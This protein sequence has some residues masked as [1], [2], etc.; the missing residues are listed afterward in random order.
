MI[1]TGGWRDCF[2]LSAILIV[3]IA[4]SQCHAQANVANPQSLQ[5]QDLLS[6]MHPPAAC[7]TKSIFSQEKI[8]AES[9]NSHAMYWLGCL[10]EH[11]Q[12]TPQDSSA[13]V[14][15]Y[16]KAAQLGSVQAINR[17]GEMYENGDGVTRDFGNAKFWFTKAAHHRNSHAMNQLGMLYSYDRGFPSDYPTALGW[18]QRSAK[19]GDAEAMN[20]VGMMYLEARG[21][22]R[23]YVKARIWF[24]RAVSK[25][26]SSGMLDLGDMYD[27]ALGV[28]KDR[29]RA[30]G[31]YK[32][33]ATLD[34][35][36]ALLMLGNLYENGVQEKDVEIPKDLEKAK[37]YY[38]SAAEQNVASAMYALGQLYEA[39]G[40][41]PRDPEKARYWYERAAAKAET[42]PINDWAGEW[43][44]ERLAASYE[45]GSFTEQNYQIAMQWY[46]K[47]AGLKSPNAMERIS[48]L[49]LRGLGVPKDVALG[50]EWHAKAQALRP[51]EKPRTPDCKPLALDT[52]VRIFA[53][54][55]FQVIASEIRNNTSTTCALGDR[56]L[57]PNEMVHRSRRWRTGPSEGATACHWEMDN[58]NLENQLLVSPTLLPPVCSQIQYS[59]YTSGPF[60][61]DWPPAKS[62]P[63]SPEPRL[64]LSASKQHYMRGEVVPL[65]VSIAD[66]EHTA[67][68]SKQGCPIFLRSVTHPSGL[69]RFDEMSPTTPR[70][71]QD[72]VMLKNCTGADVIETAEARFDFD[73]TDQLDESSPGI[74]QFFTLAGTSPYGEIRLV[75]S[76]SIPIDFQDPADLQR[77]W[78]PAKEGV[79]ASLMIDKLTYEIGEDIPLHIAA[80]VV[81]PEHSVYGEP[82]TVGGSF[83]S[84]FSGSFHLTILGED[85]VPVGKENPSNLR[86]LELG[87]SSGPIACPS[88]LEIARVYPLE[89]SA[90]RLGLLPT[91]PGTYRIT[92]TWSPYLQSDPPCSVFVHSVDRV[93]SIQTLTTVSSAPLTISITGKPEALRGVPDVPVYEGWKDRFRVVDTS[94]GEATA[95]EDLRSRLQWLRLTL[96]KNQTVDSLRKQMA[97]QGRLSGWRF[98]TRNE[99]QN[100]F[101]NFTGSADGHSTDPGI[102]RALQHLLGGPLE[103]PINPDTGWSRRATNAVLADVRPARK[104]ET[105]R[106]PA[107]GPPSCADCGVG[108]IYSSGYIAEDTINGQITATVEIRTH[109]WN[110]S[111]QLSM[112][113]SGSGILLV[114][115]AP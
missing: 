9:G 46:L 67:P 68:R 10:Y 62:P 85:G 51:P 49:Y 70:M 61:P 102:E 58:S 65:H 29:A 22:P 54:P 56:L 82:D 104:D 1:V 87:G 42:A 109:S 25:G 34:N 31:L 7:L 96:T 112:P 19:H 80:Q 86:I 40:K 59:G 15:W 60:I 77:A 90:K 99:L 69:P 41:L 18:F 79:Q 88:P 26:N 43:A 108:F 33:A 100:F 48:Y 17:L 73:G 27:H 47:A 113:G 66:S 107:G 106:N 24:E 83:M 45:S 78:G 101:A 3:W 53:Q 75:G 52:K 95:T 72:F 37:E 23:D 2:R 4:V 114:R 39:T 63:A 57:K 16:R 115:D 81:S 92:V 32:E 12:G 55:E 84:D 30:I 13:A 71:E 105:P 28:P 111:D 91:Q 6:Q 20:N 76:N 89:R 103:T 44:M 97:P 110:S 74:V 93:R 35:A 36:Y 11:G 8:A 5:N 38:Q 64:T 94:L 21:I 14:E 50:Q 98:A